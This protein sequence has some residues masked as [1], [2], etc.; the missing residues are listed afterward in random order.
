MNR[1]YMT[2]LGLALAFGVHAQD[3]KV[4]V[5]LHTNDTHSTVVPVNKNLEDTLIAGRGGFLRRATVVEQERAKHPDLLLFDS[6]D[7]SQGSPYYTMYKGEVEVGLMNV[8]GYDATTLGNHEFDNGLDNLARLVR[9][10]KFPFV[11]ANYDFTGSPLEGLVRPWTIIERQGVKIGV[12]GLTPN[13]EGIVMKNA[14]KG[15]K[16]LDPIKATQQV[17]D[18]LKNVEKCDLVVC[19]SHTGW[20]LWPIDMDDNHIISATSNVDI[21]LGGHSHTFMEKMEWVKNKDGLLVPVEQ[22]G[23]TGSFVGKVI[24]TMQPRQQ[25]YSK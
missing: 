6:G 9:M 22:N 25:S 7:F 8:M 5:M 1:I 4:L 10:A 19:L 18:H 12:F 3:K 23:N 17:A 14:I 20:D 2:L 21:F 16:Y 13:L 15:M 11:C 24:V